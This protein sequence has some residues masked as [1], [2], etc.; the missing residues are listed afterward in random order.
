MD[1]VKKNS[2]WFT[3]IY[4]PLWWLISSYWWIR[5]NI[6][7]LF[8]HFHVKMNKCIFISSSNIKQMKMSSSTQK[9]TAQNFLVALFF[10]V[11]W[12]VNHSN[13]R[14]KMMMFHHH[15][16]M[17]IYTHI[18]YDSTRVQHTH[19]M[20]YA[21]F[22]SQFIVL[23]LKI[24]PKIFYQILWNFFWIEMKFSTHTNSRAV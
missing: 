2:N 7:L 17:A 24:I 9:N 15:I 10:V 14:S 3:W 4:P 6:I 8:V 11:R 19:M 1:I 13:G 16:A 23:I 20:L 12:H 21:G 22:F 5:G 18:I